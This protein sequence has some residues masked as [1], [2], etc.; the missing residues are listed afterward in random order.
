MLV[1]NELPEIV[2]VG[3]AIW[4]RIKLIPFRVTFGEHQRDLN[5]QDKLLSERDGI[6]NF[7]IECYGEYEAA[8]GKHQSGL[9]EPDAVANELRDYRA[10][11]DTVGTF[12]AECC[13][14][15]G[16]GY[17][18]DPPPLSGIRNVVS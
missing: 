18:D 9:V 2:G 7:L 1:T 5:L 3:E 17:H 15:G 10:G 12:L 8:C 14:V 4:R 11:S 16:K 6:L 13:D